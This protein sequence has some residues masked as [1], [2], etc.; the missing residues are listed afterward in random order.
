VRRGHAKAAWAVLLGWALAVCARADLRALTISEIM[1]APSDV[2]AARYEYIELFNENPDPLD[3]SGFTIC[4]GVSFE[5]PPGTWMDGY[6]FLV[7]CADE[8]A[9]R[10]RY[11]IENTIGNWPWE[12]ASGVSLSNGGEDI[13]VCNPG[14]VRMVRVDYNDRGKWPAGADGTGHSLELRAPYIELDD[15]DSWQLS[16]EPHG[17]PGF[18]NPCWPV[19]S[20]PAAGPSEGPV[21]EFDDHRD[22]GSPCGVGNTTFALGRYTISGGGEDIW[23]NGDQFQFA[24]VELRGD[25][26]IQGRIAQR[27]WTPAQRWGKGGLMCRQDLSTRSRYV[28]VHDNPSPDGSRLAR[29]T[30]HGGDNNQ[31]PWT[32]GDGQ[33]PS[34]LRLNRSGNTIRG[35]YSNNGTGWTQFG[36]AAGT[37]TWAGGRDVLLGLAVTS[38]NGCG[39]ATLTW[40]SVEISG[41]IISGGDPAPGDD[42]DDDGRED[43][44]DP[45]VP[46]VINEGFFRTSGE[47]WIELHNTGDEAVNIAGYHLTD[48][49]NDLVKAVIGPGVSI[50]AGGFVSFTDTE[51]GLDVSVTPELNRVFVALVEPDGE[52]V[53]DAVNFRAGHDEMSEARVPDGGEIRDAADPTRDAANRLR[54]NTDI[55]LNELMYHPIDNDD[56]REFVELYNRGGST[57][58]MSGWELTSGVRFVLPAGTTLGP[59]EYL[60][61]ARN[62]GLIRSIYG[63]GETGCI[64]PDDPETIATFGSLND[65][66]ERVTLQDTLGRTVDT[67]RYHDGGG[68]PRWA[69]GHGSSVELFDVDQ[70][71]RV[72]MAWD[73]SDD[74]DK[75][76]VTHFS[77][78]GRHGGEESELHLLLLARGITVVDNVSIL[79][80]GVTTTDDPLIATDE[81]WRYRKGLSPP[82]VGWRSQDFDADAWLSGATGIGYGDGDDAT[83]LTDMQDSYVSIFCRREFDVTDVDEI[84]DLVL[85]VTVDDGFIAYLNGVQVAIFGLSD[86]SFDSDAACACEATLV[87]RDISEFKD[88]LDE[89][90]PNVLAVQVHNSGIGSSDLTFIPSLVSRTTSAD[91]RGTEMIVNPTFDS[92]TSGWM[93]EG[94]HVRSGRSTTD[95]I[96]GAGSLKIVATGRGDNKVNRIESTNG[97][98]RA[99]STT[100][101]LLI[102]FDAKWHVGSATLNT[103]GF[104]HA[105]ARTHELNVPEN[106]GTPGTINSVTQRLIDATGDS[107]LG[108]VISDLEQTPAVPIAEEDVTIRCRIGDPDGVGT[109]RLRYS[110]NNASTSPTSITMSHQGAG[111]Y[112]ATIPGRGQ[113]E[114]VVF[115]IEADDLSGNR[116]RYPVDVDERSHPL[117]LD[118]ATPR[119]ERRYVI[120]RHD[121]SRHPATPFHDYRFYMTEASESELSNRRRL[122]NELV[123]GTFTF[124]G[125]E[126]YHEAHMRFS[127]S[128]WARGSWNGSFRVA[129]PRDRPIHGWIRKFNLEDHHGNGSDAR[130]RVAHHLLR[131]NQGCG[132][133]P[134]SEVQTMA[135][136]QVNNRVVHIREHVWVPDTQYVARWFEDGD[137]DL[138]EMDDR[139]FL[140]D[141]GDRAGQADGRVLYPPPSER[142]DADGENKENY[143]WFH[144]LRAKNGAD[145]WTRFIRFCQLMDPGD[146]TTAAFSERVWNQVNVEQ[147]LRTWAIR[148]NISDWDNWS[149]DRGKNTYFY[150]DPST[151]LWNTLPW[152]MELTY[153]TGR[154]DAFLIPTSPSADFN[155]SRFSEVNRMFDVVAIKK[156]YYGILDHM[157]N[158]RGSDQAFFTSEYLAD[159]MTRLAEFGMARTAIGQPGGYIDQRRDRIR[160]RLGATASAPFRITTNGGRAFNTDDFNVNI[161]G[162]GPARICQILVNGEDHGVEHTG[163][164]TWRVDDIPLHGGPNVLQ[165]VGVN[166]KGGL[167]GSDSITV[168]STNDLDPPVLVRLEPESAP[169]GTRIGVIGDGFIGGIRCF[170]GALEA[171][172]VTLISPNELTVTVPEVGG[173]RADVRVRNVDGQE[174]GTR[175][176]TYI[177]PPPEFRRG[178]ANDDNRIDISDARTIV[179]HLFSGGSLGCEDAADVDDDEAL[180]VTDAIGLLDYLFRNGPAPPAPHPGAGPDPGGE[181][182]GC[183]R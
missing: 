16:D 163:M 65:R 53:V 175:P 2:E 82:P 98:T 95:T 121:E 9:I 20:G 80:G 47:R 39:T 123:D 11:G 108:P 134:Y 158:T 177:L 57:V 84:E 49:R 36:G 142:G 63:L 46:V 66:G 88:L 153:E 37:T 4:D 25:F 8:E 62:P 105:M 7:V 154:L 149:A 78:T 103:H 125:C 44:C 1:Y 73:A 27:A 126:V 155:P 143:R 138:V 165:L 118:G 114:K 30:D 52:R 145:D 170:F 124:G 115:F 137:G 109:V 132:F 144:G 15:P 31:E 100:Q 35:Y 162:D 17:S 127:G 160:S 168:T 68:W 79:Q 152:D 159:Y 64:G 23:S 26:N 22:V 56:D 19:K 182:I 67:I 157:V 3:L 107:N 55:V 148:Q 45:R 166:L 41:D 180:T 173:G 76:E 86:A 51:L 18:V 113:D 24:Y 93:L 21:G 12:G 74:S 6:S 69:D 13:E 117:A 5:F 174:S 71:N 48:D 83:E 96:A 102:S 38:H 99:L 130:E 54:V 106:L 40:E 90:R 139:F 122:S 91:G 70:D 172:G 29:R 33:H 120:Y 178:D 72:A 146:T 111:I 171:S 112:E 85:S 81:V 151:G 161:S 129:A 92:S 34:W 167:D 58:D 131:Y 135:R 179:V 14:G 28:F 140:N 42:D 104:K 94:T 128:P 50:P 156:L 77:Y 169:A 97:G 61:V 133:V 43:V 10:D 147:F 119:N 150:H 101:D 141:N 183:D 110:I 75:S 136:Y 176:F 32:A 59:G 116:G 181:L 87:E 164:T 60:V 89:D